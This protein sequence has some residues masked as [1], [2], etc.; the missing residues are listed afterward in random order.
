[1]KNDPKMLIPVSNVNP[2]IKN[3][4]IFNATFWNV[5]Q[6][7]GSEVTSDDLLDMKDFDFKGSQDG[8]ALHSIDT[9]TH[10]NKRVDA[11]ELRS[12]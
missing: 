12:K 1:M 2:G 8:A 7:E 5:I 6:N 11:T 10:L 9:K 3:D 4:Q